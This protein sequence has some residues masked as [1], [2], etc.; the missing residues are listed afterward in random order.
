MLV[1]LTKERY[2]RLDL[3]QRLERMAGMVAKLDNKKT[4]VSIYRIRDSSLDDRD[5]IKDY[6]KYV[7]LSDDDESIDFGKRHLSNGS[8]IYLRQTV[9]KS[10]RWQKS[11]FH[12]CISLKNTTNGACLIMRLTVDDEPETYAL[13]FGAL[14]RYCFAEEVFDRRFALL[15]TL[16]MI[17]PSQVRH[18]SKNAI[19]GSNLI[20]AQQIS[21]GSRI[22]SYDID[23]LSD[24]VKSVTGKPDDDSITDTAIKGG[25]ALSLSISEDINT[26]DSLLQRLTIIYRSEGYKDE[27]SWVDNLYPVKDK[28]LVE[29]LRAIAL[30][31]IS[32]RDG[33]IW[34]AMPE[35]V[36]LENI[37]CFR[38]LGDDHDDI[39]IDIV[40]DAVGES[41]DDSVLNR[42]VIAKSSDDGHT[43]KRWKINRCLCGEIEY[44]DEVYAI[45]D[46]YWFKV[47]KDYVENMMSYYSSIS[48][49]DRQLDPFDYSL[50]TKKQS[51]NGIQKPIVSEEAYLKRVAET[52]PDDLLL[53]DR[54]LVDKTEIC[55]LRTADAL[56]HVKRYR[57]SSAMSHEFFQGLNS[58]ARLQEDSVFLDRANN[59]IAQ[60]SSDDSYL[61]DRNDKPIIVFAIV[62]RENDQ[63]PHLPLFSKI[64][65]N[66]TMMRLQGMGFE[67]KL[68]NIPIINQS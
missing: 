64:S 43:V 13:A 28:R 34:L 41:L 5:I 47:K 46:G 25:E 66:H 53:M 37:S 36:D 22:S 1:R 21:S 49:Y 45:D 9:A 17:N 58:A 51:S 60:L 42:E 39:S 48:L 62:T 27:F 16:S 50:D 61:I 35:L 30:Q 65:L 6:E 4:R 24:F 40:L 8:T 54:R 44:G 26:I 55:D 32:S 31:S 12:N 38:Y 57:S 67:G 3:G 11:F 20:S 7:E 15:T 10:P 59:E 52:H 63:R 2:V 19:T 29:H 68:M 33:K 14:G 18:V 56:I 23:P